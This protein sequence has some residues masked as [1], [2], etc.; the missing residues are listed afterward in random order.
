MVIIWAVRIVHPIPIHVVRYV[1][2]EDGC[3]DGPSCHDKGEIICKIT[4]FINYFTMNALEA[5]LLYLQGK[6]SCNL[7]A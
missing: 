2:G 4:R 5:R 6:T 7:A 3:H 1:Q